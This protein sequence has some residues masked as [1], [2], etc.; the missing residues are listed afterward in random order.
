MGR[1]WLAPTRSATAFRRP[2]RPEQRALTHR[3]TLLARA[4]VPKTHA[5]S[6]RP[7][8]RADIL[9]NSLWA[10]DAHLTDR[11]TDEVGNGG[12][13]EVNDSHIGT[14][15]FIG[16]TASPAGS[17]DEAN[18]PLLRTTRLQGIS[19]GSHTAAPFGHLA[20][21][22]FRPAADAT[23]TAP[24]DPPEQSGVTREAT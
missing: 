6:V 2:V 22:G 1:S 17:S 8:R 10:R 15:P 7:A 24:T 21:A 18:I 14:L 19:I 20:V 5:V 23:S 12:V 4:S 11:F 9:A 16:G 3:P 13:L